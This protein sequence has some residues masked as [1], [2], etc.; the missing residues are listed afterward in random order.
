MTLDVPSRDYAGRLWRHAASG[1]SKCQPV[2]GGITCLV[3]TM[4]ADARLDGEH[5]LLKAEAA[6]HVA[7]ICKL[8]EP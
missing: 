1:G 6:V 3:R 8:S 5:V 2:I 7:H 4:L